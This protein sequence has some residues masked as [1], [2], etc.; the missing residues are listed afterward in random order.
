MRIYLIKKIEAAVAV[1]RSNKSI[2]I[3]NASNKLCKIKK[4]FSKIGN[5]RKKHSSKNFERA[6]K[7]KNEK[8]DV[9]KFVNTLKA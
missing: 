8:R 2:K 1:K 5:I 3:S 4:D 7:K 9:L 6:Y